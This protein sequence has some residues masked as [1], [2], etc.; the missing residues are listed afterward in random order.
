MGQACWSPAQIQ[1]ESHVCS[2]SRSFSVVGGYAAVSVSADEPSRSRRKAAPPLPPPPLQKPRG[3][4]SHLVRRPFRATAAVDQAKCGTSL[5]VVADPIPSCAG[6]VAAGKAVWCRRR[7]QLRGNHLAS[8]GG[9][10]ENPSIQSDLIWLS[11]NKRMWESIWA[12]GLGLGWMGS[13]QPWPKQQI[14]KKIIN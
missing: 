8:Q 5:L 12:V 11:R 14:D 2:R 1:S 10:M 7:W 3:A 13:A 4:P 6:L 9:G